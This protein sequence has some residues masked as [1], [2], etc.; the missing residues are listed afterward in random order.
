MF[1][2]RRIAIATMH[3]KEKVIS[4]LISNELGAETVVPDI[5]TDLLGTFTG[6]VERKKSVYKTA[7]KKCDIA[8]EASGCDIAI[9]SEGSFGAHPSM[10]FANANEELILLVDYRYNQEFFGK[11]LTTDTNFSGTIVKYKEDAY[12]FVEQIGFPDHAVIV[13]DREKKFDALTKGIN[14]KV[15]L[16][17]T[18]EKMLKKHDTVWIET[19]MRAMYN[20]TRM[21]S[22]ERATN[23]LIEKLNSKCPDCNYPS[24]WVVGAFKGLPCSNCGQPTQSVKSH[25]YKCQQCELVKHKDYPYGKNFENPMYC[26]FCNP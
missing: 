5:N 23:N 16:D 1:Q 10:F 9:A 25:K 11:E 4:P 26:D 20:P 8:I 2:G 17:E 14:T 15:K 13:K 19:D 7:R 3:K 12:R 6:E 21:M 22:I 24:F 18:L